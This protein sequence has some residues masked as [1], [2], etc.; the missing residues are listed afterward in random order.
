MLVFGWLGGIINSI[1][2]VPQMYKIYKTKS[3]QD[4][5]INSIYI[6]I[7]A[8]LLYTIHGFIIWDLPLFTMTLLVLI[9]YVSIFFQYRLYKKDPK[10][11]ADTAAST[12]TFI[13]PPNIETEGHA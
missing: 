1:H 12:P 8:S 5:S 9:Q 11:D 10:C 7:L 6:K 13:P 2:V 4:I 3:V